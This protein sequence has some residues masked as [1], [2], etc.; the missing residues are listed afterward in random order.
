[1]RWPKSEARLPEHPYRDS[2]ILYAVLAGLIVGTSALTGRGAAR[3]IVIAL[4]FFVVATGW[5]WWRFHQR[6][7]RERR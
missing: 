3:G 4:A 6:L 7:Q 5:T 1:M 2:A